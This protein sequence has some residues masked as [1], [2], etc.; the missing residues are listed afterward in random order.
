MF[1]ECLTDWHMWPIYLLGLTWLLPSVPMQQYLTLVLRDA[2][3]GT[4]TTNLLT[5][6]AYVIFILNL[7]FWCLLSE[8]INERFLLSTVSQIWVIP[9]LVAL[10]TLPKSRSSWVT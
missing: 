3:Y 8:K 1:W 4:F 7:Q 5:I 6:P 9:L 2:G 10:E